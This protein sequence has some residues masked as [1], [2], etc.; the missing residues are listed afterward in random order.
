MKSILMSIRPEWCEKIFKGEKIMEVR[1]TRPIIDMPFKVYVYETKARF[2]KCV[3]GA[4]TKYG[5]GSG[6]VIGSFVCD[7]VRSY[8]P[9]GLR[10]YE[11]PQ[12]WLGDMCL[13]KDELDKY[14]GLITLYGWH[15]TEPKLFDKPKDISEFGR[16]ETKYRIINRGIET[17]I[18]DY[19]KFRPLTRPPQSWCYIEGGEHE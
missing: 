3:R 14:G 8:I 13:T 4:S 9:L 6:K 11:L 18:E 12:E 1:K 2:V 10:G 5:Y 19:K 15:I 16:Y 17:I 7:N